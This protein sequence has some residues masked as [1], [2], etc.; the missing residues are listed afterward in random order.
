MY[1]IRVLI[2]SEGKQINS[3][4]KVR[5]LFNKG[6]GMLFAYVGSQEVE[7]QHSRHYVP[8][9]TCIARLKI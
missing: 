9:G 2:H 7:Y 8:P 6:G 5:N 4:T 1:S 3:A